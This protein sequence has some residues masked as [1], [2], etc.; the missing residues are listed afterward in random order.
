MVGF[1][2]PDGGKRREAW[3]YR[4]L[5]HHFTRINS[6]FNHTLFQSQ[7]GTWVYGFEDPD[8]TRAWKLV[9]AVLQVHADLDRQKNQSPAAALSEIWGE[10]ADAFHQEPATYTVVGLL[11]EFKSMNP[12]HN[13][14]STFDTTMTKLIAKAKATP[15]TERG[16][17]IPPNNV[18][19]FKVLQGG[20]A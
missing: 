1:S 18:I 12:P 13:K 9:V 16:L 20:R 15:L 7:L 14:E 11:H 3:L 10:F 4:C 19:P 5:N 8:F 17:S 2:F 6:M